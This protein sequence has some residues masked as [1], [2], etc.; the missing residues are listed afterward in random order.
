M[1]KS[2]YN[3]SA[4]KIMFSSESA[5]IIFKKLRIFMV[6]LKNDENFFFQKIFENSFK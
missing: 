2:V 1:S 4:A 3:Y 5:K 6:S